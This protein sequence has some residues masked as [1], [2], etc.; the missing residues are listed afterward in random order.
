VVAADALISL[1][2]KP[3]GDPGR[4]DRVGGRKSE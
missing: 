2:A 4:C 3:A 1:N